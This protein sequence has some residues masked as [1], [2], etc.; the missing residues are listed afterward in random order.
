MEN[1]KERP[2]LMNKEMVKAILEGR[3]TQT[4]RPIKGN[5]NFVR[6]CPLQPGYRYDG[7]EDEHGRPLPCPFGTV[8]D[9]LWVRETWGIWALDILPFPAAYIAYKANGT[10]LPIQEK[11]CLKFQ[12]TSVPDVGYHNPNVWRPSIHMPRWASRITLEVVNVRVER[13]QEISE[14]DAD[15]EGATAIAPGYEEIMYSWFEGNK[16][17]TSRD[18]R[19]WFKYKWN[20]IYKNWDQNPWVW[21][22]EFKVV[23]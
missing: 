20:S 5:P 23:E 14:E 18:S 13:V 4:R 2:I 10:S 6:W 11:D 7:W 3:K 9:R 15:K 8:G 19:D 22:V 12:F 21:V 1:R 17:V 16:V